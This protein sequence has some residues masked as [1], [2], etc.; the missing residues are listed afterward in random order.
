MIMRGRLKYFLFFLFFNGVGSPGLC[1]KVEF[2]TFHSALAE[3]MGHG[4]FFSFFFSFEKQ[5][6][7]NDVATIETPTWVKRGGQDRTTWDNRGQ[8]TRGAGSCSNVRH[9]Q[10]TM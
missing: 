1:D 6:G 8:S 9:L 3:L 2:G 4:F 5:H 10:P 7:A